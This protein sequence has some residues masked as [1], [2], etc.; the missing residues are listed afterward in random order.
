MDGNNECDVLGCCQP[1]DERYF[2]VKL[3]SNPDQGRWIWCTIHGELYEAIDR[4]N[5]EATKKLQE[6]KQASNG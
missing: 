3:S 5:R 1:K 4:L 2:S 6:L